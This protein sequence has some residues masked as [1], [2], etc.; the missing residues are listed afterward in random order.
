[1]AK[2]NLE[3]LFNLNVSFSGTYPSVIEKHP[4]KIRSTF[5]G[6]LRKSLMTRQ[7]KGDIKD[8]VIHITPGDF[9]VIAVMKDN[10]SENESP[11]YLPI[12]FREEE[13]PGRFSF[14]FAIPRIRHIYYI[15]YK[16]RIEIVSADPLP[17]SYRSSTS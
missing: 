12:F 3:S 11:A 13:N 4:T 15:G 5:P 14:P 1:M 2:D 6:R 10:P 16:D 9:P 17:D 8:C 7:K